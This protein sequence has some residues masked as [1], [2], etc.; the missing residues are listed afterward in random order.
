LRG[1]DARAADYAYLPVRGKDRDAAMILHA[2]VGY[3]VD[4]LRLDPW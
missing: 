3:P 1:N 2:D 4:M